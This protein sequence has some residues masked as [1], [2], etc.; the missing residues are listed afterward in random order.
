MTNLPERLEEAWFAESGADP[1]TVRTIDPGDELLLW[2]RRKGRAADELRATYFRSGHDTLRYVR[3]ALEQAGRRLAD[4]RRV[5]EFASGHGRVT[6]FLVRE[7]EPSRITTSEILQGAAT[8][9]SAT[10]GVRGLGSTSE[11]E[12]LDLGAPFDLVFVISLFSHLPEEKFRRFLAALYGM[13]APDGL[14]LFS[15]HGPAV[16]PGVTVDERG[17]GYDEGSESLALDASE[18]GTTAVTPAFVERVAAEVGVAHLY[19]LERGLWGFQDFYFA[20]REPVPSLERWRHAPIPRGSVERCAL[21]DA[22][23]VE[24]GGWVRLPADAGAVA[25]VTLVMDGVRRVDAE[26]RPLERPLAEHEGGDAM[27]QTDWFVAGPLGE[28]EAGDHTLAVVAE[29][30]DGERGCFAVTALRVPG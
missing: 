19:A 13:L 18:Y 14:L 9:S 4:Q 20:S 15:T 23:N 12:D 3:H 11:P 17:I 16:V 21:D 30:T 7:L 6:R 28:A 2:E 22:G 25:R 27:R 8:F 1:A 26:L 5:L 10:F 29:T 24:I